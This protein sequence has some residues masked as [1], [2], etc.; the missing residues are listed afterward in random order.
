VKISL[1]RTRRL[2]GDRVAGLRELLTPA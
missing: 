2:L 1:F